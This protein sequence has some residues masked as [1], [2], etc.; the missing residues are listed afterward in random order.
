[1]IKNKIH[2]V[3]SEEMKEIKKELLKRPNM[4]IC[5]YDMKG[6]IETLELKEK[7]AKDFG[8][9]YY[10]DE[11]DYYSELSGMYWYRPEDSG[12]AII[13]YNYS[14][15][16]RGFYFGKRFRKQLDELFT[17]VCNDYM[18]NEAIAQMTCNTYTK[19]YFFNVYYVD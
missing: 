13:L 18:D 16:L 4:N 19:Q 17:R 8:L 2:R 7:I 5:E 11:H 14:K 15:G 10:D 9:I 12:W 6:E 1:M 3:T